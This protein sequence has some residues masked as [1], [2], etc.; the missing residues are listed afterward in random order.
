MQLMKAEYTV[1]QIILH[2]LWALNHSDMIK[3]FLTCNLVWAKEESLVASFLN[4]AHDKPVF[5]KK[6][7]TLWKTKTGFAEADKWNDDPNRGLWLGWEEP[8]MLPWGN[9][10]HEGFDFSILLYWDVNLVEDSGVCRWKWQRCYF[11][12]LILEEVEL[13]LSPEWSWG[14]LVIRYKITNTCWKRPWVWMPRCETISHN[15]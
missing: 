12:K 15:I 4:L 1:V 3:A 2:S 9:E 14:R 13:E 7:M 5:S 11:P 10:F 6:S 8:Q